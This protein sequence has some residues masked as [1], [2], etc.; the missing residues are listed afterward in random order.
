MQLPNVNANLQFSAKMPDG[1]VIQ[2]RPFLASEEKLFL[3]AKEAEDL[4]S[5][6]TVLLSVIESCVIGNVQVDKLK[7]HELAYLFIQM[8]AKSVGEQDTFTI[9]CKG[10]SVD[11][12]VNFNYETDV[13]V[14]PGPVTDTIQ[15]TEE[16]SLSVSA[17]TAAR[18][19][20][21][22]LEGNGK[23]LE[24]AILCSCLD[25]LHNM[26]TKEKYPMIDYDLSEK[27]KFVENLSF[28]QLE[29][30]QTFFKALPQVYAKVQFDCGECHAPNDLEVEGLANFF[31]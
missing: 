17:P 3:V 18:I 30:L 31:G 4:G 24:K 1:K 28:P 25:T 14:K 6:L 26:K 23:D 21:L 11:N 9:P 16:Y 13:F 5:I 7:M 22:S 20:Q 29:R 8:R 2:F 27:L 19:A 12:R 15:L 10:C